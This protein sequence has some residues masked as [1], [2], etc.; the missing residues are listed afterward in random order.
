[1]E[2]RAIWWP[3]ACPPCLELEIEKEASI[4]LEQERLTERRRILSALGVPEKYHGASLDSYKLHGTK[5]E[6][7]VQQAVLQWARQY[8]VNWPN[9]PTFVVFQGDYQT[10]KT[11]IGWALLQALAH[12]GVR[13]RLT[14][15]ADLIRDLRESWRSKEGL[16]EAQRL[17][18]YRRHDLLILDE[19][20]NHGLTAK[21]IRAHLYDV[22]AHRINEQRPTIVTTNEKDRGLI[23]LL[24]GALKTRLENEGGVVE[25]GSTPWRPH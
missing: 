19:L 8:L 11:H 4:A 3:H 20:S 7:A 17:H 5:A 24:G 10:G 16:S 25:F 23:E 9:V 2:D 1:M 12:K 14:T 13:G 6:Q 21:Q 18:L 15:V 22:I